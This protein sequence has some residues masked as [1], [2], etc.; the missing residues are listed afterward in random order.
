MIN[1]SHFILSRFQ[2]FVLMSAGLL[3]A[4]S[5]FFWKNGEYTSTG[6]AIMMFAMI[7]WIASFRILFDIC[8]K[9]LPLYSELGFWIASWGA[10]S[11]LSFAWVGAYA[12]MFGI[13]HSRYIETFASF[14]I[15]TG[16][17]L[18][19]SG[20]LFPVSVLI[21]GI[22]FGI[23]KLIPWHTAVLFSLGAIL[24]PL[25]R[26]PRILWVAHVADLFLLLPLL[27]LGVQKFKNAH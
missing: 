20:P 17:L 15:A 14:P 16:F 22:I 2:G 23:R 9:S 12:E 4:A 10:L 11:G 26:I 1:S 3:F 7:A 6:A 5:T 21:M 24:F 19:W 8:R 18:F 25:S 27:Y 13:S